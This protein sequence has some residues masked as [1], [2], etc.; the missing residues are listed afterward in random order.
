MSH[1]TFNGVYYTELGRRIAMNDIVQNMKQ[2]VRDSER[3]KPQPAGPR[4]RCGAVCQLYGGVGGYSKAC[5]ACNKHKAK[6]ARQS[7]AR[8]KARKQ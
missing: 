6:L 5:E 2:L 8:V 1:F 3:L 4:C 7:R